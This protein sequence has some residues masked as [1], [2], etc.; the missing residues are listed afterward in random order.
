MS[1]VILVTGAAGKTGQA[2][3]KALLERNQSVRALVHREKQA[4]TFKALGIQVVSGD[5]RSDATLRD[6]VR[7]VEAIYHIC[8]NVDPNELSIGR[9]FI[10]AAR[11]TGINRFVFHSVLHPQAESMPHHW[12][13]LRVEEVLFESKLQFTILQPAAYMQNVLSEWRNMLEQGVYSVPYSV[14]APLSLVDL[15]DVADAAANVLCEHGHVG[16]IY[17]LSGPEILTPREMATTIGNHLGREVRAQTMPID[18]WKRHAEKSGLGSYQVETL[19]KMFDYYDRYGL[20]GNPEV[21]RG[22]LKRSPTR[23][24]EF[25]K[26]I[27]REQTPY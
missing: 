11:S 15:D 20:W 1:D 12:L 17:E 25:V 21:L 7:G 5:L 26:R 9:A 16:G 19:V 2:V 4:Q 14:E 8:P 27:V 10:S 3:I 22:L 6:A 18:D 23:F 24:E 13:K